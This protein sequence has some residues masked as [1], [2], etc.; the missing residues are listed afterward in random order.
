MIANVPVAIFVIS[1]VP[2]AI[3]PHSYVNNLRFYLFRNGVPKTLIHNSPS[4]FNVFLSSTL[5]TITVI[6][7]ENISRQIYQSFDLILMCT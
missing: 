4:D 3:L 5:A 1:N 2:V 6:V 7:F